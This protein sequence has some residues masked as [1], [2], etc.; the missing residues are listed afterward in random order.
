MHLCS[1]EIQKNVEIPFLHIAVATGRKIKE[2]NIKKVLLLG[3]KFTME[4]D[5][6]K[7]ILHTDFGIEVI[8]PNQNDREI[9]HNIIYEELVHGG[10]KF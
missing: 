5:F 9:I 3:T 10:N 1:E 7:N 4:K 6:F 2:K 8:I